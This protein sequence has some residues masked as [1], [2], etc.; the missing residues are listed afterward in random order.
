LGRSRKNFPVDRFFKLLPQSDNDVTCVRNANKTGGNRLR[1]RDI[2]RVENYPYF[3]KLAHV[4]QHGLEGL[5]VKN[6]EA[7]QEP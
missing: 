4:I 1:F 3:E 6:I 7:E 2:K 5:I